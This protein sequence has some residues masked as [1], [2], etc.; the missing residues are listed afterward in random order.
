MVNSDEETGS[1]SSAALIAEL[2]QG[3][4]AALTY[5]PVRPARWHAGPCARRQR[6]LCRHLPRPLRP[7]RAQP[8]GRPQRA[9][10]RRRSALRL[11]HMSHDDLP[12]NPAKIDGGAANNV[13]PDLAVLRF[14]IR[15]APRRRQMT[16]HPISTLCCNFLRNAHEVSIHSHGG[17][18]RPPKPVDARAQRLFDLVRE[19]GAALGQTSA[20]SHPAACATATTSPP[21][22]FPWSIP[23]A[24]AAARSIRR[25]SSDRAQPGE[26]AALSALVLSRLARGSPDL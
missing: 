21:A 10:R 3:K 23:W 8:A 1:L 26:R 7:C 18:T 14:N 12:I 16:L 4:F 9:G 2:A 20:G 19:C 17:V 11:K 25:T 15:P 22:V 6:E 13:V 5:E 24:C